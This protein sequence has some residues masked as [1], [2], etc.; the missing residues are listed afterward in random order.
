VGSRRQGHAHAGKAL[1]ARVVLD[2]GDVGPDLAVEGGPAGIEDADDG[3]AS[4]AELD[5]PPETCS[6]APRSVH[7]DHYLAEVW[8]EH[9]ARHELH[10]PV[11]DK[12]DRVDPADEH[13]LA[14]A[15]AGAPE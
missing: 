8:R 6:V 2:V 3:P 12:G 13:V 14:A 10:A 4:A 15:L 7:P 9:A 5:L 11:H 1:P